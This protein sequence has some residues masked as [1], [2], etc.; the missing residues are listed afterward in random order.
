MK[1]AFW[2]EPL[3]TYL[4]GLMERA[5]LPHAIWIAG[6]SGWGQ[7]LFLSELATQLLDTTGDGRQIAHPDLRWIEPED[8]VIKVDT[9]RR[10]NQFLL[11]T[12]QLG[13][14]KVAVIN[15]ADRMNINASNALLKI[16]EEPPNGSFVILNSQRQQGLPPT[17]ISRCQKYNV[18]PVGTGDLRSWLISEGVEDNEVDMFMIEY[19]HAPYDVL[20]A[21]ESGRMPL[22][23][24]LKA[25]VMSSHTISEVAEEIKQEDLLDVLTRWARYAH[26]L[27]KYAS[28]SEAV[29]FYDMLIEVIRMADTNTGLNKQIQLEKLL[30]EWRKLTID[31]AVFRKFKSVVTPR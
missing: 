4:I 14:V 31:K 1:I 5:K 30:S 25:D 23:D 16:L 8:G 26:N 18:L 11:Q 7:D 17:I 22:W 21:K 29:R 20:A 15:R 24:I 28:V 2:L 9:I 6:T 3:N 10:L 13:Q 12:P 19:G 27:V